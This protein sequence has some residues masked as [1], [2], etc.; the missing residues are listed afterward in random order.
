M[1]LCYLFSAKTAWQLVNRKADFF[2]KTNRFESIRKALHLSLQLSCISQ[3]KLG[4][5][6]KW[7]RL[8][9]TGWKKSKQRLLPMK[10][11]FY[12]GCENPTSYGSGHEITGREE[13]SCYTVLRTAVDKC[14]ERGTGSGAE[15]PAGSRGRAPWSGGHGGSPP[16]AESILVIG[17]PT[18]PA[19]LAPFQKC[20]FEL[21]LQVVL[22]K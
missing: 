1:C 12:W 11:D 6:V 4:R 15:P 8:T 20:P 16:E 9:T 21:P 5:C 22:S 17:C 19:N 13:H 2:Y 3:L 14:S 10:T 7:Q 18:E